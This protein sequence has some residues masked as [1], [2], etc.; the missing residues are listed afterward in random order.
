M[1]GISERTF[2]ADAKASAKKKTPAKVAT[3][4]KPASVKKPAA[5]PKAAPKAP[6]APVEVAIP[7]PV[8]EDDG[9]EHS[10]HGHHHI[11]HHVHHVP[12]VEEPAEIVEEEVPSAPV[13]EAPAVEEDADNNLDLEPKEDVVSEE[14]DK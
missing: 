2:K 9:H 7:A 13:E 5:A 10:A 8:G 6:A 14:E 4:K 1:K 11:H 12:V 3:P